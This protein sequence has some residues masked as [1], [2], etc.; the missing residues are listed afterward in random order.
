MKHDILELLERE[1]A[2]ED[3]PARPGPS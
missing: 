3:A 1:I 2:D